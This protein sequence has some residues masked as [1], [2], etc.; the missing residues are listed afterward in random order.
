MKSETHTHKTRCVIIQ[1]EKERK[2]E[3]VKRQSKCRQE[4]D[5]NKE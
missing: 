5:G 4:D 2:R 1:L 3:T